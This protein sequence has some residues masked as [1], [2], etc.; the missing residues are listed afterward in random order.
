ML[1]KG[2]GRP[3]ALNEKVI[4]RILDAIPRV[5]SY[6]QIAGLCR[7]EPSTLRKWL[8]R[9][10]AEHLEGKES[11]FVEFFLAF[12]QKK[13]E[14]AE[15]L[16]NDMRSDKD[17]FKASSW[18]LER[19]YKKDFGATNED[20]RKFYDLIAAKLAK[21]GVQLDDYDTFMEDSELLQ[22]EPYNGKE[23]S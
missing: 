1:L 22:G 3:I 11:I 13:A 6:N 18:L 15:E 7:V 20:Q 17:N 19:A 8:Y 21:A 14:C 4:A 12:F 10:K 16:V 5:Y 2:D 9:G 23:G